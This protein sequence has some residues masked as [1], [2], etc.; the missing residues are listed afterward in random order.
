MVLV[1]L[2]RIHFGAMAGVF[3]GL[4]KAAFQEAALR[5]PAT[6]RF[7]GAACH[8]IDQMR[9]VAF[10]ADEFGS[11]VSPGSGDTGDAFFLD[12]AREVR[13][14]CLLGMQGLS[15]LNARFH[16]SSR[17]T[18]LL[19][20]AVTKIFL[21]SDCPETL[22]F[23]ERSAPTKSFADRPV[24]WLPLPGYQCSASTAGS[25]LRVPAF[26]GGDLRTLRTGCGIVLRPRG[27]AERVQFS[28][29]DEN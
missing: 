19:N 6:L 28:R 18:H 7:D 22:A 23:F 21:A 25:G 15:A 8:P 10:L 13:V 3:R 11:L 24:T 26:D 29:F 1:S 5:R 12:K 9:P 16:H 20:N 27:F 14:A 2:S 17:S 4:I